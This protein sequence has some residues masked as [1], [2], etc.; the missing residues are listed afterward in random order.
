MRERFDCGKERSHYLLMPLSC[1][2]E[3]KDYVDVVKS[4]NIRCLEVVV[5]KG[6]RPLVVP[7]DVSVD[8]EVV[9]NLTQEEELQPSPVREVD[10]LSDL[11]AIGDDF[12]EEGYYDEEAMYDTL[13]EGSEDDGVAIGNEVEADLTSYD[14]M[15]DDLLDD[16]LKGVE[17]WSDPSSEDETECRE[18]RF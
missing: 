11:S 6:S 17:H 7:V 15:S 1:E 2:D 12:N 8:V 10:K 14:D 16:L 13:S 18:A 4:S 3:W 9:E 5:E